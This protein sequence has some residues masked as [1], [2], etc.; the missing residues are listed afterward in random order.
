M[1]SRQ[2][3]ETC[4]QWFSGFFSFCLEESSAL[5]SRGIEVGDLVPER[6]QR[7]CVLLPHTG[8]GQCSW[9][10]QGVVP[11][12][13]P[14]SGDITYQGSPAC[15]KPIWKTNFGKKPDPKLSCYKHL[16]VPSFGLLGLLLA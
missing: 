6:W 4:L 3:A 8:S 12:S 11:V 1:A 14:R 9:T 15:P 5:L 10:A 13:I 2:S 16:P 7:F